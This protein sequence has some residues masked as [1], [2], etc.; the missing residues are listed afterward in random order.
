MASGLS[1]STRGAL[2]M[3][4]ACL[5]L[6]A[7]LAMVRVVSGD[8]PVLQIVA[9]RN[10]FSL[11]V[12]LPWL[13]RVGLMAVKTPRVGMHCLRALLFV[14][15][16]VTSVVSIGGMPLA[17]VVSIGF[18][19]PL[20]ATAG[21]ALF[22]HEKVG[23]RRWV[24]VLVGF[25]GVL[26]IL[27]PGATLAAVPLLYP[28]CALA[29]AVLTACGVMIFKSLSR[30]DSPATIVLYIYMLALP[31]S[32]VPALFVWQPLTW[33]LLGWTAAMGVLG[34]TGHLCLVRSYATA[35]AS[36]V[37]PFDFS[38][39]LFATAIGF[40]FLA[41]TP[42][43]WTWVGAAIIFASILYTARRGA[44]ASHHP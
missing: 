29:T 10:A 3:I 28:A 17:D 20:F 13:T 24:A 2:W 12:M 15:A 11:L 39:M 7:M 27:R 42:D 9:L 22:L 4:A 5:Q 30:T 23:V 6:T 44:V 40:F 16:M 32:V 33:E 14:S 19:A 37:L 25:G 18:T 8:L 35:E 21:A 36:A 43:L 38:R 26:V 34:T 41:E 1:A 31:A